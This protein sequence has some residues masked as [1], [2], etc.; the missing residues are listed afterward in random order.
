MRKTIPVAIPLID[1]M[2]R[3]AQHIAIAL[4]LK[5]FSSANKQR[6]FYK[7]YHFQSKDYLFILTGILSILLCILAIALNWASVEIFL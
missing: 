2:L 6:T 7:Q 5:A 1:G 4:E 3:R